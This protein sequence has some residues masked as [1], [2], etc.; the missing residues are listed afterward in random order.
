[1][2]LLAIATSPAPAQEGSSPPADAANSNYCLLVKNTA[3][4]DLCQTSRQQFYSKQ[5]R[6][7]LVTM[8]KAL[9]ASPKEGIIH[10]MIARVA[11]AFNNVGEEERELR[12]GRKQ[13]APDHT[14]LPQLFNVLIERH[15]ENR[16]LAEFTDPAPGAKGDTVADILDGRAKALLSLGRVEEAAAEMDRALS[17][18]RDVPGLLDRAAIAARQNNKALASKLVDE[19]YQLA[20]K[21]GR[22]AFA[23]LKEIESSGDTVKTLAFS[24]QL[25]K[26]FP[27][28]VDVRTVRIESFLKLNQNVKAQTE[29]DAILAQ[30]PKSAHG[31][32]YKAILLARANDK[33]AAWQLML[34]L[35][36]AFVQ[37]NP[38]LGSAIAQIA[39]DTGHVEAGATVLANVLTA[40]PDLLD[41]RLQ[42]ADLRVKQ[43]TPQSAMVVLTP[44]KDSADPRVKKLLA[45]VQAQIAKDRSF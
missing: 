28:R 31:L 27:N 2:A 6:A 41:V 26:L 15:D 30:A 4:R 21:E 16:L 23:K 39:F 38:A 36:P 34:Q 12:E 14:V 42:L 20:P 19:A 35:T 22:A 17:L 24:E 8:R 44:V 45:K 5:F 3:A 9:E 29:V 43:N 7:S 32:Y 11:A 13:G 33:A 18:R 1:M 25:L 40:A 37:Q 10:V